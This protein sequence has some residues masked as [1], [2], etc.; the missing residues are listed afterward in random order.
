[1]GLERVSVIYAS[2]FAASLP[3]GVD[4]MRGAAHLV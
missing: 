4:R 3:A 1:L 2:G